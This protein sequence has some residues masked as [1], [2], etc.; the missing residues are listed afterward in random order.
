MTILLAEEIVTEIEVWVELPKE[1]KN[2]IKF[3]ISAIEEMTVRYGNSLADIEYWTQNLQIW[4]DMGPVEREKAR[5][6]A[7]RRKAAIC[8]LVKALSLTLTRSV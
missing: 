8:W 6:I 3:L 7:L 5:K 1:I 2:K 4:N